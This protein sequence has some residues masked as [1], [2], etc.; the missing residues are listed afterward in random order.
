MS[1][2]WQPLISTTGDQELFAE[3]YG[4]VT[5]ESVIRF[6][7][8]D[9][10]YDNSIYRSLWAARENARVVRNAISRDMWLRINGLFLQV[11]E[12][13]QRADTT[14]N[15]AIAFLDLVKTGCVTVQGTT[16]ATLSRDEAWHWWRI[17]TMLER[18]DKTSRILDVKYYMLLPSVQ[19]VGSNIDHMQWLSL[20]D[21]ASAA[22]MFLQAGKTITPREVADFLS[23]DQQFPRSIAYA[24]AEADRSLHCITGTASGQFAGA[25]ERALGHL[26]FELTFADIDAVIKHGLHE[27]L[28]EQQQSLN[29]IDAALYNEYFGGREV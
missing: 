9:F 20:L 11:Q 24:I 18:A 17:G 15:G 13:A 6:L 7:A 3:N 2:A 23:L 26:R 1:T 16:D 25:A 12:M 10:E 27:Y 4:A 28:D 21:S 5:S 19:E 22:R 8:Y 14:E 29:D